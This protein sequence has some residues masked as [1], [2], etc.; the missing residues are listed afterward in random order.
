MI[1]KKIERNESFCEQIFGDLLSAIDPMLDHFDS[2]RKIIED[3]LYED[4]KVTSSQIDYGVDLLA[5]ELV[6]FCMQLKKEFQNLINLD[7]NFNIFSYEM[8]G[9]LWV[10]YIFLKFLSRIG[11]VSSGLSEVQLIKSR[12]RWTSKEKHGPEMW[13]LWSLIDDCEPALTAPRFMYIVANGLWN[14]RVKKRWEREIKSTPAITSAFFNIT[15]KPLITQAIY[16]DNQGDRIIFAD[17]NGEVFSTIPHIDQ[18][19]IKL[20]CKGMKGFGS[21]DGQRLLRW[22]ICSGFEQWKNGIDD[23]RVINT[24]GGYEGIARIIGSESNRS[25]TNVKALLYAQAYGKFELPSGGVGNMLTLVE[26]E[27]HANG[28][29]SKISLTLGECLMPNYAQCLPKGAQRRL[30]P[31][32]GLP[33]LVCSRNTH[34]NQAIFQ[35]LILEEFA[36]QSDRLAN[37]G[38]ILI[39]NELLREL[40]E[41]S[42]MSRNNLEMVMKAWTDD[43]K[44]STAFLQKQGDEYSLSARYENVQN[45]LEEQGRQRISGAKAGKKAAAKR[46]SQKTEKN[47]N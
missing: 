47:K 15:V 43:D 27:K 26:K 2:A 46:K 9:V 30:V 3:D 40:C 42:G 5:R 7:P 16:V 1:V 12:D 11:N 32:I 22:E 17:Q 45:F 4:K 19:M 21:M 20:I 39:S 34:A 37:E 38:S 13:T 31:I 23:P 35:L 25:I 33:P 29:P 6:N 44:E 8:E 18:S 24:E 10:D 41:Q 36:K 14:D 28:Q